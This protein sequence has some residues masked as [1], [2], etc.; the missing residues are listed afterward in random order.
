M[1]NAA[2][3]VPTGV[4]TREGRPRGRP[5]LFAD[6]HARGESRTL[7]G[8]PPGD[9][10]SPPCGSPSTPT[11]TGERENEPRR[12]ARSPFATF[13]V[14]SVS[15]VFLQPVPAGSRLFAQPSTSMM[16]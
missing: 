4:E 10:E 14:A 16:L 9:F 13:R 5:Y 15:T 1:P 3:K 7:T 8:L 11:Y 6:H 2:R 12:P